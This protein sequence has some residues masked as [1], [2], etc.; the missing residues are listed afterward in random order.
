MIKKLAL[1]LASLSKRDRSWVLD[2]IPTQSRQMVIELIA[3]VND[4]GLTRDKQ[5]LAS[6]INNFNSYIEQVDSTKSSSEDISIDSS[7]HDF[8]VSIITS[9]SKREDQLVVLK[10]NHRDSATCQYIESLPK[11]LEKSVL[12]NTVGVKNAN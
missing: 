1:I 7:I 5:V 4:I 12:Q 10:N 2:N 6:V 8:W 11:A 9:K 3:E